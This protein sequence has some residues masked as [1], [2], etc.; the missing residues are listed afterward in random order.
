MGLVEAENSAQAVY[1]TPIMCYNIDVNYT[2]KQHVARVDVMR[3]VA[4]RY[5]QLLVAVALLLIGILIGCKSIASSSQPSPK[6][7]SQ[8]VSKPRSG[9]PQEAVTVTVLYDNYKHDPALRTDWGFSCLVEGLEKTILFD[10]GTKGDL[11]L[12][13]MQK[14][15]INPND[16]DVVVLSHIHSD[17]TGGLAALLKRNPEVT[18]FAPQSF[19]ASFKEN[20]IKTGAEYVEVSDGVQICKNAFSTGEVLGNVIEQALIVETAEG[21]VVITG[22]AHPGVVNMVR[23]ARQMMAANVHAV[24]GGFH[25]HGMSD[26]QIKR[27]IKQL[28]ELGVQSAGPCHCSGDRTRELFAKE[29]GGGYIAAGVGSKLKFRAHE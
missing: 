10:T 9:S 17:H 24:L 12:E 29:F 19:P 1:N 18:V 4:M 27:I 8:S 3:C 2:Y 26:R 23:K 6:A 5:R 13:N 7:P 20:V 21:P 15:A 28:K 11:L 16:V 22:C 25:M 14:L